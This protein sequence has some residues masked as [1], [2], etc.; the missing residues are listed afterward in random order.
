LD[1]IEAFGPRFA[2]IASERFNEAMWN[3]F[4]AEGSPATPS[5]RAGVTLASKK[6]AQILLANTSFREMAA[7]DPDQLIEEFF[8]EESF[9]DRDFDLLTSAAQQATI[10]LRE[11]PE[12]L[13]SLPAHTRD[14]LYD[15][16]ASNTSELKGRL[17]HSILFPVLTMLEETAAA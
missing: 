16:L 4:V 13:S 6:A 11:Q 12:L 10:R 1:L 7:T 9:S 14:R 8:R 3:A 15:L 17:L 5:E 2:S